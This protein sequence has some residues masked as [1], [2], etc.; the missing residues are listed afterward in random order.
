MKCVHVLLAL[1]A[2]SGLAACDRG[3]KTGGAG[4]EAN[5]AGQKA[6]GAGKGSDPDGVERWSHADGAATGGQG[7]RGGYSV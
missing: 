6:D 4:Q 7:A 2:L 1:V 5:Q 3:E